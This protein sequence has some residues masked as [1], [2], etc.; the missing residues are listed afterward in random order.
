MDSLTFRR[1]A[2][3]NGVYTSVDHESIRK[4]TKR[5]KDEKSEPLHTSLAAMLASSPSSI[6]KL[7]VAEIIANHN[8]KK[9]DDYY[10]RVLW[11]ACESG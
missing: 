10:W 7:L 8:L 4:A 2:K 6:G 11:Q 1:I 3:F 9:V 5:I